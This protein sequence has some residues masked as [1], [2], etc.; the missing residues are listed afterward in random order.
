MLP[1]LKWAMD[2]PDMISEF[3]EILSTRKVPLAYRVETGVHINGD[4][5]SE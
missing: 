2:H 3:A 1:D 5:S 4:S